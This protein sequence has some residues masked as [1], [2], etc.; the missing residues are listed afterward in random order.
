MENTAEVATLLANRHKRE[1]M[2]F[3][4]LNKIFEDVM[5]VEKIVTK[6]LSEKMTIA[7][8]AFEESQLIGFLISTIMNDDVFGRCAWVKYDGMALAEGVT[9]EVYRE[10]YAHIANEWL[11]AGCQK[12]YVIAPCGSSDVIKAWLQ[13]GFAYEQVFG[14]Q[15]LEAVEIQSIENVTV[16]EPSS[17][18][19]E[20]IKSISSLIMS[21]QAGSPTFAAALPEMFKEIEKGYVGLIEDSEAHVILAYENED[22]QG[23]VC[24]YFEDEDR[25][26]MMIPY[27]STELG[28]AGTYSNSQNKGI[29]TLL[30][31]SLLNDALKVGYINST[32]DWRITNLKSSKFWP[33][34]GYKPYAY[35][36][37]RNIDPRVYW[38]DGQHKLI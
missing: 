32:T 19:I 15:E 18:D 35:R 36:L 29:G 9:E 1:R 28:V 34:M 24:G 4:G 2:K 26:N 3:K 12:H 13:S 22:V 6:K 8:G 33:R 14:L 21:Y 37:V 10:L 25:D 30:T 7:I 17:S 16:R 31:Q 11:K 38:A 23:F 20:D 5:L 27:K